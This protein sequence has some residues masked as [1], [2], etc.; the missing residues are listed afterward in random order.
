MVFKSI[1]PTITGFLGLKLGETFPENVYAEFIEG[2]ETIQQFLFTPSV[3][4]VIEFDN[5]LVTITKSNLVASVLGFASY[6]DE[7]SLNSAFFAIR[8][9]LTKTHGNSFSRDHEQTVDND[10]ELYVFK[11]FD[12]IIFL[13]RQESRLPHEPPYSI[14]CEVTDIPMIK[15]IFHNET[16]SIMT[17]LQGTS[18]L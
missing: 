8:T 2:S 10:R 9:D 13:M 1:H 16:S 3:R 18:Y 15:H 4:E 14:T 5:H 6:P 7:S 17:A 11:K 12:R